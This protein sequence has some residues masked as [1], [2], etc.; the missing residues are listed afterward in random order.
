MSISGALSE[1]IAEDFIHFTDEKIS[2]L[3]IK[4][5]IKKQAPTPMP[6]AKITHRF[7]SA[8]VYQ[9]LDQTGCDQIID[10]DGSARIWIKSGPCIEAELESENPDLLHELAYLF[11]QSKIGERLDQIKLFRVHAAAFVTAKNESFLILL[12]SGGGKSTLAINLLT[13]H[14]LSLLSDDTPIINRLGQVLPFPMRMAFTKDA[15]IPWSSQK[16]IRRHHGDKKLVSIRQLPPKSIAS[17]EARKVAFIFLGSRKASHHEPSIDSVAPIWGL[18]AL[19]KD[20]VI[21]IGIPQVAELVLSRSPSGLLKLI[22]VAFN[23]F[24]ASIALIRSAKVLRFR[25]SNDPDKNSD[26]LMQF[27]KMQG[28]QDRAL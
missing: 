12:P 26:C 11:L 4:L 13:K 15:V 5:R 21:G 6:S 17:S 8:N 18:V 16:F 14:P 22:P 19:F 7:R 25:L 9:P 23:R 27:I 1:L 28:R 10:Y 24:C 20:M 2:E 3:Q